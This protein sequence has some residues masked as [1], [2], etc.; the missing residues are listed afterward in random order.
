MAP[1]PA[2][3]SHGRGEK[4]V[5]VYVEGFIFDREFLI[6]ELFDVGVGD[7][8]VAAVGGDEVGVHQLEV[9]VRD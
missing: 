8:H 5:A 9:G 2:A 7:S 4:E 1:R 6:P 3:A